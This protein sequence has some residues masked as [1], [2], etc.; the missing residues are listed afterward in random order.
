MDKLMRFFEN[1][2]AEFAQNHH[3]QFVLIRQPRKPKIVDFFPSY[4]DAYAS[5]VFEAKIPP[6]TFLIRRCL[7]AEEEKPAVFHS[8][9]R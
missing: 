3:R 2:Q 4:R 6:E 5:A 1:H 7:R 9:V 8:R